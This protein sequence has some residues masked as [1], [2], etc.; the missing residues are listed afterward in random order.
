M[1]QRARYQPPGSRAGQR[2][3]VIMA[4]KTFKAIIYVGRPGSGTTQEIQVQADNIFK[5]KDLINM[6]YGNPKFYSQ[7]VE[8][9]R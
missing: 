9:R 2:A 6:Q 5:A 7:P 8:V 4:V 1:A 3:G